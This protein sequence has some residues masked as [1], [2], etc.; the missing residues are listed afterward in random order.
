MI[1]E[2]REETGIEYYTLNVIKMKDWLQ[3]QGTIRIYSLLVKEIPDVYLSNEHDLY[4]KTDV[5]NLH[6]FN[7]TYSFKKAMEIY[8]LLKKLDLMVT[9]F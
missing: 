8:Q 1:R 5:K 2:L 4:I 9:K 7:L 3:C 6:K